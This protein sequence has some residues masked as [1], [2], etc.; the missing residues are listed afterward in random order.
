M[1]AFSHN[2]DVV[3]FALVD[4]A[5]VAVDV[6]LV[7][8]VFVKIDF[9]GCACEDGGDGEGVVQGWAFDDAEDVSDC[10]AVVSLA[11]WSC[12]QVSRFP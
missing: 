12:T 2:P 1:C 10:G 7:D 6:I 3:P 4:G 5:A 8:V 11:R 9:P